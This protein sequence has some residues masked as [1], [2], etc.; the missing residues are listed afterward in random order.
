MQTAKPERSSLFDVIFLH[1]SSH[2]FLQHMA[3][4]QT[5]RAFLHSASV[6]R[7][8]ERLPSQWS[9]ASGCNWQLGFSGMCIFHVLVNVLQDRTKKRT[10]FRFYSSDMEGTVGQNKSNSSWMRLRYLVI[11]S[12]F[13]WVWLHNSWI[14]GK[15]KSSRT[16]YSYMCNLQLSECG[17]WLPAFRTPQL[18]QSLEWCDLHYKVFSFK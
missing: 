12:M 4:Q 6:V 9:A 10:L 15:W 16:I 8:M 13:Q 1:I 2:Q 5:L 17:Q 18:V 11:T 3:D 14:F 7:M